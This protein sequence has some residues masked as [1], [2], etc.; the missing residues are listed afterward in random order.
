MTIDEFL[1][2][3]PCLEELDGYLAAL[4]PGSPAREL[5][6]PL[7]HEGLTPEV[8]RAAEDYRMRL[9]K[10]L[11][12]PE[13]SVSWRGWDYQWGKPPRKR[14]EPP[15]PSA[16]QSRFAASRSASDDPPA[17]RAGS[18]G[19]YLVAKPRR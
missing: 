13:A 15:P 12:V 7:S 9:M 17:D 16:P 19:T 5:G 6:L 8:L 14:P 3:R 11:V 10:G 18:Q 4:K 1:R 2:T